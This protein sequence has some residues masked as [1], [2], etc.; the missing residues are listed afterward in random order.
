MTPSPFSR[1]AAYEKPLSV[2]ASGS[3]HS[4]PFPK[5]IADRVRADLRIALRKGG[6][7]DGLPRPGDVE[8]KTEVRF[9][10]AL[11]RA[12][13]DPDSYFVDLWA[14]GVWIAI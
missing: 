4:D 13:S 9:L 12:F 8:Q 3:C 2:L 5:D 6:Y 14:K 11:L 7:G 1:E 10:Q